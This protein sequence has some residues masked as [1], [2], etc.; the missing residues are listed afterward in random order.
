MIVTLEKTKKVQAA[1]LKISKD[2]IAT[3]TRVTALE[4]PGVVALS[5]VRGSI[6]GLFSKT[7]LKPIDINLAD[8]FAEISVCLDL[9]YGSKIHEVCTAVQSGIKENVQ[10]MTGIVVSKVNITVQGIKFE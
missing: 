3:I 6:G 4:T 1:S 2:V 9:D 10:T 7:P 8:D 5:E